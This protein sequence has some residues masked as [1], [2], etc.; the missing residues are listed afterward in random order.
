M[1]MFVRK[2]LHALY[3]AIMKAVVFFSP[4]VRHRVFAGRGS[5][6][7]L[8]EHIARTGAGKVLLAFF[9]SLFLHI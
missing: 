2:G 5:S 9:F 8:C 7:Q 3:L 6:A 4:S 1:P